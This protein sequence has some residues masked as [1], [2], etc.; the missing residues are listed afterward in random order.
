MKPTAL[1]RFIVLLFFAITSLQATIIESSKIECINNYIVDNKKTLVIFD[2]DNTILEATETR[3]K[4][5]WFSAMIKEGIQNGL[6]ELQAVKK[7]LPYYYAAHKTTAVTPVDASGPTL[8]QALQKNNITV[9]ALTARSLPMIEHTFQ[10][11]NS[12]GID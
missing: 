10:Q 3:A 7:T 9:I 8:V 5:V 1:F 2:I 6:S 11:L 4:D 12:L